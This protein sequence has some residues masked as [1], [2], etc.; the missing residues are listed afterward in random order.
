MTNISSIV[1]RTATRAGRTGSSL[2]SACFASSRSITAVGSTVASYSQS[3][4]GS[5]ARAV[6]GSPDARQL[7]VSASFLTVAGLGPTGGCEAS[8]FS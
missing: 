7:S 4:D 1:G 5:E 8:S 3:P 6:A 2:V